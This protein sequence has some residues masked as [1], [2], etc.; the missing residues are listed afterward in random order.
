MM[1]DNDGR[2]PDDSTESATADAGS[3]KKQDTEALGTRR[4]DRPDYDQREQR[5]SE[6]RKPMGPPL[7]DGD[8]EAAELRSDAEDEDPIDPA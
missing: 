2:E 3:E 4:P 6:Q 5:I 1:P 7:K 8:A